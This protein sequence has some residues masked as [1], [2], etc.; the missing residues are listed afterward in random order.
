MTE[1]ITTPGIAAGTWRIDPGHSEITFSV[2]H[3]MTTVRGVFT[4]FS[5]SIDIADDAFAS[6]VNA[7]VAIA[8]IDTRNTERDELIRSSQILDAARHP[9]MTFTATG[10]APARTGRRARHPRYNV[11]GDLTIRGV[12]R[13]VVLLTEFHG[14]GVDQWGAL[15]AG[16]TASTRILRSDHGIEFNIPLQGDRLVLGDEIEVG[17]Q[18]QAVHAGA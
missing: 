15:R 8:S 6:V 11:E 9:R 14:A 18:I 2:R 13:P 7:E 5:G 1:T 4:E 12:T 16:F 3:M 17:L 10:V